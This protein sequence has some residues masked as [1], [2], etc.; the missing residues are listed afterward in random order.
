LVKNELAQYAGTF[1]VCL[2]TTF[3]TPSFNGS[4]ATAIKLKADNNFLTAAMF[5]FTAYKKCPHKTCLLHFSLLPSISSGAYIKW[6]LNRYRLISL[7]A[8]QLSATAET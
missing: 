5:F 4:L 3:H 2:Y 1:M 7:T 8:R 6:R